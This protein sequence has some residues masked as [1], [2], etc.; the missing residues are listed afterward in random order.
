MGD[1]HTTG[2][3]AVTIEPIDPSAGKPISFISVA[4]AV[5]FLGPI[6]YST[7]YKCVRN[8]TSVNGWVI[9]RTIGAPT[10]RVNM[11]RAKPGA[12]KKTTTGSQRPKVTAPA[13]APAPAP[14]AILAPAP[15]FGQP[16]SIESN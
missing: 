7:F 16:M 3:V 10:E 1:G 14:A 5:N 15:T 6:G 12:K 4:A 11:R 2:I 8:G 13:S 9:Q